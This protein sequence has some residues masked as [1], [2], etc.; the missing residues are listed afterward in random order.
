MS[1]LGAQIASRNLQVQPTIEIRKGY[2]LEVV[3][4]RDIIFPDSYAP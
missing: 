4:N 3:V 1:Q 2:R